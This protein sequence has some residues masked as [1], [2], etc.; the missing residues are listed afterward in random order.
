MKTALVSLF[1]SV[2][3]FPISKAQTYTFSTK[4]LAK[5]VGQTITV[6]DSVY[7]AKALDNITFLNF[8]G[9]FPLA[10][11]T[12]VVFKSSRSKFSQE[13]AILYDKKRICITGKL[14]E[15]KG[16]LQIVIN[17]GTQVSFSSKKGI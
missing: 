13:P 5:Y 14:I 12:L 8:G 4:N 1:L 10:P 16:K 11:L 3:F 17:E 2:A 15:Y 6:C 9:S 7:S